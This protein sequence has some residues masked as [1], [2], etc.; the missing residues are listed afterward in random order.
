MSEPGILHPPQISEDMLTDQEANDLLD[1][2][3]L[4]ESNGR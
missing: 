4:V 1:N 2:G 3:I